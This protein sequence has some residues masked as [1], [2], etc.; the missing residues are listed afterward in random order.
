MGSWAVVAGGAAG[1]NLTSGSEAA[2]LK[3]TLY[4]LTVII[5][6]GFLKF[7]AESIYLY[8]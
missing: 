4:Y 6:T 7:E 2:Y 8:I 1:S 5:Y 3:L